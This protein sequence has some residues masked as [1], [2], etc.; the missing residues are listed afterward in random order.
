[1]LALLGNIM[2]KKQTT[3]KRNSLIKVQMGPSIKELTARLNIEPTREALFMEAFTHSSY[4][5]EHHLTSNER[6][7]FLG[8]SI[9]G[10]I[11]CEYLFV[12]YQ[13]YQEGQLAKIKSIVVSAPFLASFSKQMSLDKYILLGAGEIR[14]S[15]RNKLNIIADLFEAFIGAYYLNFGLPATT[16]LIVPFIEKVLPEIF[17][18]SDTIDAKTY[19]QELAQSHGLKP[20]YR[21]VTEVGPPHNKTFTVEVSLNDQVLGSGAGKSLKEA[22]NKAAV[23]ATLHFK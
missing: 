1:M 16:E 4:A 23:A 8:D 21:V 7:E 9:L 22:Q 15:G 11:V 20:E 2:D 12:H 19:L 13:S 17:S 3:G 18:Q 6:L 10:L 5:N 14:T